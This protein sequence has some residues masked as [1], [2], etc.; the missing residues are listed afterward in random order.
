MSKTQANAFLTLLVLLIGGLAYTIILLQ[1]P[2]VFANEIVWAPNSTETKYHRLFFSDG[3]VLR[4]E[5]YQ[6]YDWTPWREDED[7]PKPPKG[8]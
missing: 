1:Q 6:D 5:K 4:R 8:R 2:T 3:T 7:Y